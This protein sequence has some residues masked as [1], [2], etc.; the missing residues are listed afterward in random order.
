MRRLLAAVLLTLP[1]LSAA[2]AQRR[3]VVDGLNR[4]GA[5]FTDLPA[6]E[7]AASHSDVIQLRSD[8][9]VYRAVRT[10]K[11]ITAACMSWRS[12]IVRSACWDR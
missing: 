5:H 2:A 10:S 1:C 11:G 12:R 4:A 7:T 3:I 9:G 6:A 8:G